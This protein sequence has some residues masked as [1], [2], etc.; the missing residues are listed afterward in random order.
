MNICGRKFFWQ[1]FLVLAVGILNLSFSQ[2]KGLLDSA[3]PTPANQAPAAPFNPDP[4]DKATG[5]GSAMVFS[6]SCYDSDQGDTLS[7]IVYFG[8]GAFTDTLNLYRT[9]SFVANNL[10]AATDY[11]W[12]V[13]AIDNHGSSTMGPV[14]HF[15][16]Y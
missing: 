2:D 14:W 8:A 9:T 10:M 1:N 7:Y 13:K 11:V 16:T 12:K 15:R 6:W 4:P 3:P 5:I